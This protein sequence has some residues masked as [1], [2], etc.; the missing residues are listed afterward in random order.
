MEPAIKNI[1]FDLGNVI[2]KEHVNIVLDG[3]D[4]DEQ[5]VELLNKTFFANWRELDLGT[6]NVAE[7]FDNCNLKIDD[8]LK[9][10][11]IHYYEHRP[12]NTEILKIMENLRESGYKIFILSNNNVDAVK[13]FAKQKIFKNIDGA[14]YSC[15]YNIMKPDKRLYE[16]L[17]SKYN[18]KPEECFFIDDNKDNIEAG[19][20]LGM[21]GYV[22]NYQKDG[23]KGL[24]KA[25]RENSIVI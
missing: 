3:L 21:N 24:L 20:S 1:I 15:D 7:H 14:I 9:N 4:L 16:I 17:F 19:Q 23:A 5:T 22:L 2:L 8:S 25:M 10:Y 18:L 13:Y 12:F 11:L 6:V